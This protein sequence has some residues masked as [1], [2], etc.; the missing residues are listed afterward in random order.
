[1]PTLRI[2]AVEHDP[3]LL[4]LYERLLTRR[5]HQVLKARNAQ[6]A[7]EHL[8][9]QLDL[10]IVDL[11][12]PESRGEKVLEAM[13]ASAFKLKVP[14]LILDGKQRVMEGPHSM[15]LHKPF[16]FDRFVEAVES[17]ATTVKHRPN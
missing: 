17:L 5:G 7:A 6:E 2:L 14:V 9:P 16:A 10:V 15:M 1:M 3:P 11:R 12:S 4:S 8:T 13:R